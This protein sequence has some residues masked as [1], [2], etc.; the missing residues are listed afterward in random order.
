M[1]SWV[2]AYRRVTFGNSAKSNQKRRLPT[3]APSR[4]KR[5]SAMGGYPALRSRSG[6]HRQAVPGLSVDASASLP[7]PARTHAPANAAPS[8]RCSA[9]PTGG[10]SKTAQVGTASR[11]R[12]R[13]RLIGP[14]IE[15][16][17]AGRHPGDGRR[18]LLDSQHLTKQ[19]TIINDQNSFGFGTAPAPSGGAWGSKAARGFTGYG[20]TGEIQCGP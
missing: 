7:R 18:E 9:P 16:L 10:T 19:Q 14:N 4:R 20:P 15:A 5:R 8:L 2:F 3:A 11:F 17:V 1:K 12:L 13:R 6:V